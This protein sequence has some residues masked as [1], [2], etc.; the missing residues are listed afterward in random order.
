MLEV[1]LNRVIFPCI[2]G[3]VSYNPFLGCHT[4]V[5][6]NWSTPDI[7][8]GT[9]M[10]TI[11][12]SVVKLVAVFTI[13]ESVEGGDPIEVEKRVPYN[14]NG[15]VGHNV[16]IEYQGQ[17]QHA[18]LALYDEVDLNKHVKVKVNDTAGSRAV[19][20]VFLNYES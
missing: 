19:Y 15:T 12:E 16:A 6:T 13:T 2:S 14:G 1:L 10:D 5:L 11:N 4:S 17:L 7:K 3:T 18:T 20:G 8:P 9:I